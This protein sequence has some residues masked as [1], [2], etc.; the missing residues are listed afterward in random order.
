[1]TLGEKIYRLRS[2]KGLSQEAFGNM[3]G[4][5]RQSVSKW[6]TDQS[7][8]ELEKIV[9]ISELFG[10]STDYLL[11]ENAERPETPVTETE[12]VRSKRPHYEYISKKTVRG[13]PLVHVNFGLGLYRA[14]GIFAIGNIA[15][16]VFALGFVSAGIISIGLLTFGLLAFGT[17]AVGLVSAGTLAVG[18]V[19]FGA[20]TFGIFCMGALNFGQ[21]CFGALSYG[22]Q[23]AIG[24]EAHGKIA[25]GF[26]RA[27][28]ELY[29]EV[30]KDGNFDYQTIERLIDE[31]VSPYWLPFR[32]WMKGIVRMM[33]M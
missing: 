28:G 18:C 15:C 24:D 9:A 14:K 32:E 5:S 30:N 29:Q 27:A 13:I 4:V 8:P 1:M 33:A 22:K 11:K 3:L 10:V 17:I 20:F 12:G 21:F 16:G 7:L 26:S 23:V 6:E 31:N 2:E 19:A 25:L